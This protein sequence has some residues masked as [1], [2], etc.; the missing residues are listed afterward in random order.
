[1]SSKHKE[2]IEG[3]KLTFRLAADPRYIVP[4]ILPTQTDAGQEDI[5]YQQVFLRNLGGEIMMFESNGVYE[6]SV[7]ENLSPS[8]TIA[9]S[10]EEDKEF[11]VS[12]QHLL[13]SEATEFEKP[14]VDQGINCFKS[15]QAEQFVMLNAAYRFMNPGFPKEIWHLILSYSI[16]SSVYQVPLGV[17]TEDEDDHNMEGRDF[18]YPDV[19]EEEEVY[20]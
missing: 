16:M 20:L 3:L 8:Q 18:E 14:F 1:M 4:I 12:Y 17:W 9:K 6:L 11:E 7:V 13:R 10:Y 2:A 15:W 19:K 5:W